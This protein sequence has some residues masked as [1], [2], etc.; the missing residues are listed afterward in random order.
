MRRGPPPTQSSIVTLFELARS[1]R[2]LF[3]LDQD[4]VRRLGAEIGNRV[5]LSHGPRHLA[6]L[7]AAVSGLSIG[8]RESCLHIGKIN[9]NSVWMFVLLCF[10]VWF[11]LDSEDS[12]P[13]ILE[14]DFVSRW[15]YFDRIE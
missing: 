5:F 6:S 14:F 8:K 11:E 2:D 7:P 3:Q 9:R 13:V 4:N 1:W 15:V 12:H 10:V